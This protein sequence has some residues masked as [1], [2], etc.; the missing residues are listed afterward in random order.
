MAGGI[1][2]PDLGIKA[3]GVVKRVAETPGTDGVDGYH[4]YLESWSTRRKR[5][6]LALPC[7]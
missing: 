3:T 1:D 6:W 4:V 7:G 2:E 5:R